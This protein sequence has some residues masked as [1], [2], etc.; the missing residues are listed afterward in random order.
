[1]HPDPLADAGPVPRQAATINAELARGL[2]RLMED[3]SRVS[4]RERR[5]IARLEAD[6]AEPLVLVPELEADVH[7]LRGL[8]EVGERIL[9]G[10]RARP[11]RRRKAELPVPARG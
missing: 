3:Q 11:R 8:R 10:G 1:V 2:L 5:G 7:D 6:V 4:R 9:G